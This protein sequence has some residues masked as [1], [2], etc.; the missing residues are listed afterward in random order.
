MRISIIRLWV[1]R[2]LYPIVCMFFVYHFTLTSL[3]LTPPNPIKQLTNA[4][5]TYIGTFNQDWRLF[6]PEPLTSD[7]GLVVQ[8][9]GEHLK[10]EKVDILSGLWVAKKA[11]PFSAY[12]R[13]GRMGIDPSLVFL[14]TTVFNQSEISRAEAKSMCIYDPSNRSCTHKR[15]S[16]GLAD[17]MKLQTIRF[18][19]LF[20]ADA[21][22]ALGEQ[23]SHLRIWLRL[24][25]IP[26]W[27]EQQKGKTKRT[28]LVY[29]VGFFP[30]DP[31]HSFGLWEGMEIDAS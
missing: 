16:K 26:T 3:F 31:V 11:N 7:L 9:E 29:K 8:C 13:I 23:F 28:V 12:E 4:H 1:K 17:R 30:T 25:K 15:S 18:A 20:C 22:K 2:F 14:N 24:E 27:A 21:S 19:S 10:T 6:A 5:H